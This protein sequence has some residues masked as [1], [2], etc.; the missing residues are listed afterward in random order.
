MIKKFTVLSC[1][2]MLPVMAHAEDVAP[3][4]ATTPAVTPELQNKFSYAVGRDIGNSLQ[5]VR[6]VVTV[7]LLKQGIDDALANKP[8]SFGDADLL[9]AKAE[10]GK[11]LQSRMQA[12]EIAAA[13]ANL[14]A[15][16]AFLKKNGKRKGVTTT[17]SGLQYEVI[18]AAKG[19]HPNDSSIVTVNYR[20]TL[21][22]GTEFDSSYARNTPATFPL[23]QVIPGWTEG[24]QLMAKGAKY[25]FFIPPDLAYAERGAG[26]RI[27]PNSLLIFEVELISFEEPPPAQ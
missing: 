21:E 22:D 10:M 17:A 16:A 18:T 2:L 27:G 9:A 11:A 15:A 12:A 19:P 24:V 23:G 25:R 7:D 3:A 6:D 13:E 20:G 4:A 8:S 26:E 1:F 14:K 5:S